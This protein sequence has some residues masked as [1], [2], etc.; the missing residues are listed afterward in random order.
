MGFALPIILFVVYLGLNAITAHYADSRIPATA[1]SIAVIQ[2]Q[3][4]IAYRNAVMNFAAANPAFI[5]VV[6]ANALQVYLPP[7][8]STGFLVNQVGNRITQV[9]GAGRAV[10]T[11]GQNLAPGVTSAMQ[12]VEHGNAGL[13]STSVNGTWTSYQPDSDN[14]IQLNL[15]AMPASR[16]VS[17]VVSN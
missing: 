16:M 14:A 6:P 8:M 1:Q 7:G 11:Y 12:N 5:G 9:Q 10:M 2:A 17:V 15:A 3:N 4:M 13:G